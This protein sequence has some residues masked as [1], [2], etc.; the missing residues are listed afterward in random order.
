MRSPGI[1]LRNRMLHV[2][3]LFVLALIMLTARLGYIQLV[4]GEEL[5]DRAQDLRTREISILP[6]RGAIRD[7][8][9]RELA[10]SIDV[11]SLY[12]V[13]AEVVDASRTAERIAPI[14]GVPSPELREKLTR[15]SSFV[16]IQRKMP[17]EAADAIR[18]LDLRGF[19]FTRES[20]RFYPKGSLAAAVLGFAGMDNQGL[21]GVEHAYDD[22]LRGDE[23]RIVVEFDADNRRIPRTVY[24]H[25]PA[26]PGDDVYLT[27]DEVLQFVAERE[28][29][30]V[31]AEQEA[32]GGVV[33]LM[34]PSTGKIL[35][36]ASHPGFNLN[37]WTEVAP[38]LWRNPALS[39]PDHPGSV[40]KAITAAA[41]IDAGIV[42]ASTRFHDP[43]FIRVPGATIRNWDLGSLGDTDFATGFA[44]SAN[45]VFVQVAEELGMD[46]FYHYLRGFGLDA[47]TGVALPGEADSIIPEREGARP[48]DLAVMSFGQTLAVTPLQMTTA[49]AAIAN[50]GELMRPRIVDRIGSSAGYTEISPEVRHRVIS[51]EAAGAVRDLMVHAVSEGTGDTARIPGYQVAGKT[52]TAQK[53]IDGRVSTDEYLSTFVGFAPASDPALVCFVA[54][55]RPQKD[56]FGSV[57]AAPIFQTLVSEAL[58]HLSIPPDRPEDLLEVYGTDAEDSDTLEVVAVPDLRGMELEAAL[59][60]LDDVGL[61]GSPSDDGARIADQFPAP[62]STLEVGSDVLLYLEVIDEDDDPDL[63]AVPN[64]AGK[65]LREAAERLGDAGLRMEV[66]GSGLILRQDPRAGVKVPAGSLVR[67]ELGT[68]DP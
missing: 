29:A 35:A 53:T 50:G 66:S 54:I 28:L 9:G 40:F 4:R 42:S 59:T 36:M 38:S 25:F 34:E 64:V 68:P 8:R 41:A 23:G 63:V 26:T 12:V 46:R 60:A 14:L 6:K 31:V 16:W 44:R 15:P 37:R 10:I 22:V 5:G 1:A 61:R 33:V 65:T 52:G 19:H 24:S 7:V 43:G 30:R 39:S 27:I 51:P 20:E 18:E 3:I 62:G 57:V 21:E 32:E 47:P 45:V 13:P 58:R 2:L 67:L 55:D 48:V 49:M 11:D 56:R 17:Q